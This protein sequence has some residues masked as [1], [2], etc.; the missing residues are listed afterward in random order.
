MR[1]KEPMNIHIFLSVH[2]KESFGEMIDRALEIAKNMDKNLV[3]VIRIASRYGDYTIRKYTTAAELIERFKINLQ[4]NPN[5]NISAI[6]QQKIF[7]WL[8]EKAITD[9]ERKLVP[10]IRK[11]GIERF[12]DLCHRFLTRSM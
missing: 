5:H 8:G 2:E 6:E 3:A 10:E 7:E 9:W 1:I 4:N 12:R 11:S